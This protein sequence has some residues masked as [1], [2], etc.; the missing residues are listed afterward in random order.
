MIVVILVGNQRGGGKDLALHLM[1]DENERVEIHELRGFASDNL[2]S[3]FQESYAMSRATKCKQ[4][5]F[6]LS[7][8]PPPD[9]DVE[10]QVFENAVDRVEEKLGLEGQPRTIVFHEKYGDD[11]KLRRHAHAVWCRID[12]ENMKAVQLSF[13]HNKLQEIA[14]ELYIEHDWQM[15]RGFINKEERNPRNFTLA[16]W[17]QAKRAGKDA[18]KTKAQFQDAWTLSDS[19]A[20]FGHALNERGYVLAQ[21][22]RGFVAV[23]HE[24]EVYPVSRWVGIKSKQVQAKLGEL[25]GLPNVEE[26]H[27]RAAKMIT[28]R[29]K[30]IAHEQVA[31]SQSKQ[32]V[33][34]ADAERTHQNQ[35]EYRKKLEKI[36]AARKSLEEEQRQAKLR[37]GLL[38]FLD[39]FTGKRK[40]TIEENKNE[41]FKAQIRDREEWRNMEEK[42]RLA[43]QSMHRKTESI[44]SKHQKSVNELKQDIDHIKS[45]VED[46]KSKLREEFKAK[47]KSQQRERPKRRSSPSRSR[48][49][50]SFDR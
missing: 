43:N 15:P 10:T 41:A 44:K 22:R 13:T 16:E 2:V 24:G 29:L 18:R 45:G 36:Q 31:I 49:R 47:R 21:G 19:Q 46:K 26:A 11:G 25:N 7:L 6:S 27:S 42:Q 50:P 12:T 1:K 14:R 37:K 5:L 48:D 4:H 32:Q 40:R 33:L 20:A 23:D 8:N 30:E 28:D 9:E 17:Q 35:K 34:S 38:G 3:A 39:R